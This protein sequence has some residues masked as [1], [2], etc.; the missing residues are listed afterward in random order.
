M[1]KNIITAFGVI[2]AKVKVKRLFF[3]INRFSK[4]GEHKNDVL[5]K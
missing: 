2:F 5:W 4:P 3:R 1:F